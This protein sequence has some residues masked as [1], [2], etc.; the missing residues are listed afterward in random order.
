LPEYPGLEI[1]AALEQLGS[2][3]QPA[4]AGS[5]AALAG[6]IAAAVVAKATRASERPTASSQALLLRDRLLRLAASDA[7][8]LAEAREALAGR[9]PE[10]GDERRDFRLGRVLRQALAVPLRIGETCADVALLAAGEREWVQ[11]DYQPDLAA[12]AAIAA[13]AAQGAAHLVAVNLAA[14]PE[15]PEVLAARRFASSADDVVRLF[16]GV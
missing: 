4:A 11:P 3:S 13:G 16:A 10:G 2:P 12:A 5:A 14:T 8:A 9:T 7:S 1:A 6:A 15:D